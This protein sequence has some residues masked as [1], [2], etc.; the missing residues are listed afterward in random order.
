MNRTTVL[1]EGRIR[2]FEDICGRFQKD[3]L[4]CEAGEDLLGSLGN[5]SGR[6]R[7]RFDAD[8]TEGSIHPALTVSGISRFHA[9]ILA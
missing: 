5:T 3:R 1:R 6:R 9:T 4:S 7:Q 8:G 2:R